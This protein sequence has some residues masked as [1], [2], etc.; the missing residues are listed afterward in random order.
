MIDEVVTFAGR[1]SMRT[2]SRLG[3]CPA[4]LVRWL[5]A[6]PASFLLPSLAPKASTSYMPALTPRLIAV[7]YKAVQYGARLGAS[8]IAAVP[9]L[10][11]K[12]WV[13]PPLSFLR[14]LRFVVFR[15]C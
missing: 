2:H 1:H 12:H 3:R 11:L 14:A 10:I 6:P 8:Q 15:Q 9:P 7:L 5:A 4:N 13:G